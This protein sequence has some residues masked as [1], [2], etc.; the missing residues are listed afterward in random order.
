MLFTFFLKQCIA[1]TTR[2]SSQVQQRACD[3]KERRRAG[4]RHAQDEVAVPVG[5]APLPVGGEKHQ[6]RDVSNRLEGYYSTAVTDNHLSTR[7]FRE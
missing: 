7:W 2:Y 5:T 1:I 6:D 4:V 3:N